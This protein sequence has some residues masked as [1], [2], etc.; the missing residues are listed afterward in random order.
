MIGQP[1]FKHTKSGGLY[2]YNCCSI[3]EADLTPSVVYMSYDSKDKTFPAGTS[4]VRP[5][6]QFLERFTPENADARRSVREITK[7]AE[8]YT[9]RP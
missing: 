1:L 9:K 3:I 2:L 4:W 6:D 7:F 5:V 8:K